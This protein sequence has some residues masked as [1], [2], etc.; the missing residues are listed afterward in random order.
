MK[1]DMYLIRKIL[2]AI[3]ASEGEEQ[4]HCLAVEGT[5]EAQLHY[6][7]YL[8]W[9]AGL[10]ECIG[11]RGSVDPEYLVPRFMTW[12]DHEFL[13]MARDEGRWQQAMK[14]IGAKV[15]SA[16]FDIVKAVL[17]GLAAKAMGLS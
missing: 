6:H 12:A 2:L 7:I 10:I 4:V 15:G 9:D 16:S 1:R 14:Q 17:V 11:T 8:V 5:S 3:E 13:D